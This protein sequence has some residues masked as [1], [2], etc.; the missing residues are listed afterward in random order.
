M[1]K[2]ETNETNYILQYYEEIQSGKAIVGKWVRLAYEYIING[3]NDKKFFFN[4]KK[5]NKAIRFIETYLHH[6]KGR[7]DLIKLELWQKAFVSVVFGVVDKNNLRQFCTLILVIGRKNGKS[8]LASAISCCA[9]YIDGEYGGEIYFIAPKLDQASLCFDNLVQM[10]E[11][12][13]ELSA[14]SKKRRTD[15]YIPTTN[16]SFKKLSY[17]YRTSDGLSP[18]VTVADEVA[19]WNAVQGTKQ[20]EVISSALG[21]RKQP[22]IL[23]ISTAGSVD[24]GPYDELVKRTTQLY[25]GN[26]NE[27]KLFGLIYQIDDEDKWDDINELK[28]SNPNM[29]VSVSSSFFLE[30]IEKAKVS[31]SKK[32]EFL[33]KY[34]NIKQTSASSWLS[35]KLIKNAYSEKVYTLED[36][37]GSYCTAGLD[38]SSTT[39]LTSL[40]L[41]ISKNGKSYVF[42]H[43]WIPR[44]RVEEAQ[45]RDNVP[46]NDIYIP[47]GYVS[48]S[49]DMV[50]D[51]HDVVEYMDMLVHKYEILP[52]IVGY[53]RWNSQ[54]VT[55]DLEKHGFH[56]D[57]VR[58]NFNLSPAI[59][60]V[61]G[62]IIEN[63]LL[64]ADGNP[65][66]AQ[67]L[68]DTALEKSRSTGDVRI[69][70]ILDRSSI[71]IDGVAS[72]LDAL[73]VRQKW[74][75]KYGFRLENNDD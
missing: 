5:A 28:K 69:T 46:Y 33:M 61:E 62:L 29:D 13:P 38:L 37:A 16:T 45:K 71:H 21:S 6:C 60:E 35:A 67:H 68:A 31:P 73:I 66:M 14:I 19:A 58:Q 25:L 64:I 20:F 47:Q 24:N 32:S 12:S 15:I 11:N 22:L 75:D 59:R 34:C 72:L 2:N 49:G 9:G 26:S 3:L 50:I 41:V 48:P 8:L 23:A 54:Y 70:K 36:F 27:K 10:V 18:H 55:T 44:S 65:L 51:Y 1:K 40:S 43:Y 17:N 7:N 74:Y 30:E 57:S 63:K 53:D 52:L 56:L 4:R 42:T 39:D